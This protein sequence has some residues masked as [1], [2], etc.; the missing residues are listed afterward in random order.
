M[1]EDKLNGIKPLTVILLCVSIIGLWYL[2]KIWVRNKKAKQKLQTLL[3]NIASAVSDFDLLTNYDNYFS[4]FQVQQF[5]Q[6]TSSLA[7]SIPRFYAEVGLNNTDT[8][9]I[10][11]FLNSYKNLTKERTA[12][13][14]LFV[15]HES[16]KYAYLFESLETYP[17]SNDQVEAIVRDEDNN[18]VIAGAGTG[19]TTTISA[20]VAYLLEKKLAKPEDLLIISF[21]KNAVN[22][23]YDR[24]LKFCRDIPGAD[25]LDVRTF[26]SF[27]Y[28]VTRLCSS[29]EVLLAFD[30]NDD[31]AK[32]F[33]QERFSYLFI[34][35]PDFQKKAV[36][37]IAFFSRPE[38]DEFDYESKNEYLNYEKSYKNVT[39]DGNQVNSNEEM[40]I[41]NFLC[42]FK[43]QYEYQAHYP[44]QPEDRNANFAAYR[45]DFYFPEYKIW[46]EHY[47]IDR[48]GNVPSWF[49]VKHPFKTAKETYHSGILWKQSI[50]EKYGT[51]LI[52][53]HSYESKDNTLLPNLKK[54]LEAL[55]VELKKRTVEELQE[56]IGSSPYYEDF[57]GLVHTLYIMEMLTTLFRAKLTTGL[58]DFWV[59]ANAIKACTKIV[60]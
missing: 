38:R 3:P 40:Q 8:E 20:K 56:L 41:G 31:G 1:K 6:A 15:K 39:L 28:F 44:L 13:N 11:R 10:T 29:R 7:K 2:W 12:Y 60:I 54:Q 47:G 5:S 58:A 49:S 25:K 35:D 4:N 53:T 59:A 34:N 9:L 37:F 14:D 23:M 51:T 21:T 55:G 42:L 27:G 30:G 22:E 18:L 26:N 50:H 16:K 45:P 32:S 33:L 57:I 19:K 52:K 48:N 24:C 46:H 43:I 36:N 17:L